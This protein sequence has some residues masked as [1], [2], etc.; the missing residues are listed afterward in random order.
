MK[1]VPH[2]VIALAAA[3]CAL[4][5][6]S[7]QAS[8]QPAA[9]DPASIEVPDLSFQPKPGDEGD[10]DKYFY[11][12]RDDTD[13]ATAYSDILECDGYARGLAYRAGGTWQPTPY[14]YAG[15]MVGAV[16]GALGN[17]IA[18]VMSEAI[19]GSAERRKQRRVIMRTCMGFK[20][21]KAY[22]LPRGL[23]T[24]FNFEEGLTKVEDDR[25]QHLL[26][27]QAK[28]AS[29]PTPRVGEIVE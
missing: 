20:E 6:L 19:F 28:V 3:L 10:Y 24:K 14:P 15:T 5:P 8:S 26:Q 12:H 13:F 4:Q 1:L 17:V 21:Y 23:W 27:V 7:A 29:G 11:F 25:R 16:G 22:G 18:D 2:C 9:V